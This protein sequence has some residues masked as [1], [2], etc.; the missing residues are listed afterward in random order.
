M[1]GGGGLLGLVD[2]C[3]VGGTARVL[4]NTVGLANVVVLAGILAL[5]D[6]GLADVVGDGK[7]VLGDVG[8]QVVAAKASVLEGFL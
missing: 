1:A 6:V 7:R 3:R 2:S 4:F 8:L 5:L